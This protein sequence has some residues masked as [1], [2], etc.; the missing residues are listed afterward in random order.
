MKRRG[1]A[2]IVL[3]VALCVG[4]ALAQEALPETAHGP[5]IDQGKGYLVEEIDDGL[6]WVSDGT[7]ITMFLVADEGVIVVD[8]PPSLG[9]RLLRAIGEVTDEAVT[10]LVYSHAHADHIGAAGIFSDDVEIIAH[11]ETAAILARM[12][13]TDLRPQ[14]DVTFS[15]EYTLEV[16]D[17]LLE[18]SY[19]GPN[20]QSGNIFIH[21]P[22][23]RVLMLVDVIFPGWVPFKHLALAE[24]VP[25]FIDAHSQAL[26][27][28]FETFLGGHLTRPGTREDIE[29]QR[30]YVLDVQA[31][32]LEA[33]QAVDFMAI[34]QE[35]GFANQW[36]LFDTYLD[37]VAQ[38]CAD[39][40]LAEWGDR[41]GGAEAFTF[42]HCWTMMEALRVDWNFVGGADIS[43]DDNSR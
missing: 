15:R 30:D 23:Q 27:F 43:L 14:P 16:G 1:F 34:G 33:L 11:E 21:A 41:L 31:N 26:D 13:D 9:D 5:A 28:D 3:S 6:Y 29:T 12:G 40:T 32:A 25:G 20:H 8:A 22:S 4:L 35:V 17:Q 7:Y 42:S 10:H 38:V 18:L 39:E 19:L 36:L 24:D 2:A 37:E